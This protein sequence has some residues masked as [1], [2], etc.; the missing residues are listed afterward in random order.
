MV[1]VRRIAQHGGPAE[2][3]QLERARDG[4]LYQRA[5][6]RSHQAVVH[7]QWARCQ[8]AALR[9]DIDGG[10]V[11]AAPARAQAARGD[12][13]RASAVARFES[14]ASEGAFDARQPARPPRGAE[15]ELL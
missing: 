2:A 6:F 5:D 14:R 15:R 10:P 11:G 9:A 12:D 3:A 13:G 8:Y 4:D 7:E 1:D